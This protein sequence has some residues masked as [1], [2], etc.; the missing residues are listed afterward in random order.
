MTVTVMVAMVM[1]VM[2]V[3]VVIMMTVLMMVK[4]MMVI[5]MEMIKRLSR[6]LSVWPT[7]ETALPNSPSKGIP[8]PLQGG[9]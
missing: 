2:T 4:M 6:R 1:V 8:P 5:L 3:M 7:K 9:V